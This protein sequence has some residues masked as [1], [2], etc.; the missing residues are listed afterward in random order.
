M[1]VA[2]MAMISLLRLS[3]PKVTSTAIST[4]SGAI[5]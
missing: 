3:T 5:W 1:P 2:F 4:A